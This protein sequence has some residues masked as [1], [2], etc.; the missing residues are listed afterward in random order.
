METP[1]RRAE[2]KTI[3]RKYIDKFSS[4]EGI[5]PEDSERIKVFHI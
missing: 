5:N 1:S 3:T 2:L 4:D